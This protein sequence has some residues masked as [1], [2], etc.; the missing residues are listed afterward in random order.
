[1][2]EKEPQKNLDV[3]FEE[4]SRE[5]LKQIRKTYKKEI[6]NTAGVLVRV[7][8]NEFDG[9]MQS[10]LLTSGGSWEAKF[11]MSGYSLG[12]KPGVDR[13]IQEYAEIK[14]KDYQNIAL[15]GTDDEIVDTQ[16]NLYLSQNR[17]KLLKGLVGEMEE[18]VKDLQKNV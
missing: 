12:K 15:N 11:M 7:V 13:L 6:R 16:Q 4:A 10:L 1:M 14:D 2:K 9:G 18:R 8:T 5:L 3:Q 17:E